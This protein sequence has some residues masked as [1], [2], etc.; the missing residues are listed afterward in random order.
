MSEKYL[1]ELNKHSPK[2]LRGIIRESYIEAVS[3]LELTETYEDLVEQLGAP[4]A[5]IQEF[6]N[7]MDTTFEPKSK[8]RRKPKQKKMS[9]PMPK[10]LSRFRRIH[11]FILIWLILATLSVAPLFDGQRIYTTS[12]TTDTYTSHIVG[13]VI[14]DKGT[15]YTLL[16]SNEVIQSGVISKIIELDIE[17]YWRVSQILPA[18][19]GFYA[20]IHEYFDNSTNSVHIQHYLDGEMSSTDS[21][22]FNSQDKPLLVFDQAQFHAFFI[23]NGNL[24]HITEENEVN[25][26]D[27]LF[28]NYPKLAAAMIINNDTYLV[29][30]D[31]S[32]QR[33]E[34]IYYTSEGN[35]NDTRD[36][37]WLIGENIAIIE[38]TGENVSLISEDRIYLMS[39]TD[40]PPINFQKFNPSIR[41]LQ[42]EERAILQ[43]NGGFNK[44]NMLEV[45][46]ITDELVPIFSES[47]K[48][49]PPRDIDL[50]YR[51]DL[52]VEFVPHYW[53]GSDLYP[54]L[55]YDHLR[56]LGEDLLGSSYSKLPARYEYSA[57]IL[58][59]NYSQAFGKRSVVAISAD[60]ITNEVQ[61]ILRDT[62]VS[63][64]TRGSFG[65][66]FGLF[67]VQGDQW[68]FITAGKIRFFQTYLL[69]A[70]IYVPIYWIWLSE[71][72]K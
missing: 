19:K 49:I 56:G 55:S 52:S 30:E 9:L 22:R 51:K 59:S 48:D 61:A 28:V 6:L 50:S 72:T 21:Y 70:I 17:P 10:Y 35:D 20:V 64:F 29:L 45:F 67:H 54:D 69:Y 7:T 11:V 36:R 8:S 13:S 24:V 3:D 32:S 18:E 43:I 38:L 63:G 40:N 1:Y 53:F 42:Q 41:L 4:E 25:S 57:I 60:G 39:L 31:E 23:R 2:N 27:D 16:L 14:D 44:K 68:T 37:E 46:E 15:V 65:S 5:F 62:I 26:S 33:V 66:S 47:Y 58:S 71:E 12:S 34:D